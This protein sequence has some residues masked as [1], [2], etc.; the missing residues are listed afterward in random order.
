MCSSDLQAENQGKGRSLRDGFAWG[1]ARGYKVIVAMDGDGQ[2]LP[3]DLPRLLTVL[4]GDRIGVVVGNRMEDLRA[5]PWIR[6]VTNAEM[7][8]QVSR[9]CGQPIPDTQCGFRLLRRE[10][11]ERITLTTDRYEIES[12]MLI[13]AARAG[14]RIASAPITTVYED[15]ESRIHPIADTL[16][17]FRFLR[18]LKRAGSS[19]C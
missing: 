8:R 14:F 9:L 15:Q 11:L 4:E 17:F 10:V 6:R 1:L 5:M 19:R 7:S 18:D 12:E 2:H 16:R 3:S 13:K